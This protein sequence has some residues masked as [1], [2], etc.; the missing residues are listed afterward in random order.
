MSAQHT[1][2][3]VCDACEGF[4]LQPVER[5]AGIEMSFR[6]GQRVRHRDYKGA[7][8]TGIVRSLS[9]ESE[10]GLMVTIALDSPIVIPKSG[11]L[12]RAIEIWTQHAQAHE[13]SAFDERDELIAEML[14]ACRAYI[15]DREEA[16]CTADSTAVKAMRA[17]I[18]KAEGRA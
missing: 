14:A 17:A 16:G 11:Y 8:V 10:T 7:R 4:C 6:I 12:D 5:D 13:F 2:G 3:R 18:A 1:P 15:A 9:V